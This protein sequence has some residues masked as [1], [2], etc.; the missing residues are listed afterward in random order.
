ME[1]PIHNLDL[2][3]FVL[4]KKNQYKDLDFIYEL[5]AVSNH[6]GSYL[7]GHYTTYALNGHLNKWYEFNDQNV[8]PINERVLV[9]ENAYMLMYKRKAIP[10]HWTI[11]LFSIIFINNF[12]SKIFILLNI[13]FFIDL[14]YNIIISF[15]IKKYK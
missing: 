2:N 11:Y 10:N 6:Y 4:G 12:I 5:F 15:I 7:G 13:I 8:T 3:E 9:T 14:N 1:Y